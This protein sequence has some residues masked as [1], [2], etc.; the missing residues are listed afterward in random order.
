MSIYVKSQND[1][2]QKLC[3]TNRFPDFSSLKMLSWSGSSKHTFEK[4][5]YVCVCHARSNTY[6]YGCELK[7][8]STMLIHM[9]S[10]KTEHWQTIC[11]PASKGDILSCNQ[12][13]AGDIQIIDLK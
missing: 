10:N 6:G 7:I 12:Y 5:C 13:F 3:N 8:N 1:N 2:C 9:T 4:D 11:I